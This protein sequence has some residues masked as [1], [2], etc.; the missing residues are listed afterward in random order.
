M[1]IL[2]VNMSIAPIRGGGTA[3]R[4]V[5]M[6]NALAE[7]GHESYLLTLNLEI[8]ELRQKELQ[9]VK[10][11]TLPCLIERIYLPIPA[12]KTIS[13]LVSNADIIHLMGH[14][15]ILNA[16]VYFY[17]RKF[18]KKYVICPAGALPIFG[19]S[20]FV[21]KLY[22]FIVGNNIVK[23]SNAQI[24]ITM[25]EISHLASYGVAPNNAVWI[26]NG[27][28]SE[29][30]QDQ[31]D[32]NFRKTYELDNFPFLLY[33]GRLNPIKGPDL[34][35]EAFCSVKNNFPNLHLVMAGPDEGMLTSLKKMAKSA[36]VE[37]RVHFV[38]HISG[39]V[40]SNGLHAA[41]LMV[42]PSRQEA[43]SIV[44]L[45]GGIVGL[46][47]LLTDQCGLNNLAGIN[48]GI[49]V[50]ASVE[51]IRNGLLNNLGDEERLKMF[52]D[53]LKAHVFDNYLWSEIVKK[54]ET[55]YKKI[56]S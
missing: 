36:H 24:V 48:A 7:L 47:V 6:A 50:P 40:K 44:V 4:T 32:S 54:I 39:K 17:I 26:P 33:I 25:D 18:K 5:Q 42:I 12:L 11:V 31:D 10:L 28:N 1:K 34:L 35:L 15:T 46:P 16:I 37:E 43:M 56:L 3:E 55:L 49:I 23:N 52:G 53:N 21:K 13:D 45:E 27:I 9:K 2:N 51:G 41:K 38:G 22:N 30:L 19:R 8:N 29:V 20:K 14:W